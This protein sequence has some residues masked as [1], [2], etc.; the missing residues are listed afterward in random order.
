MESLT[1][2]VWIPLFREL[3]TIK[4]SGSEQQEGS[5]CNQVLRLRG[6]ED[7][8]SGR[9][10]APRGDTFFTQTSAGIFS[11][12]F[13]CVFESRKIKGLSFNLTTGRPVTGSNKE[14]TH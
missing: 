3:S 2:S 12:K 6:S 9:V 13:F 7:E 5:H 8:L 1:I 14:Q 4:V 11:E 10:S